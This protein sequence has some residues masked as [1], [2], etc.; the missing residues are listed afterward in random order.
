MKNNL[1]TVVAILA[2]VFPFVTVGV[3]LARKES[4]TTLAVFVGIVLVLFVT[5][6]V[7]LVVSKPKQ[8]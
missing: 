4:V 3:E 1:L 5:I 7:A 2:F 6:I 8:S